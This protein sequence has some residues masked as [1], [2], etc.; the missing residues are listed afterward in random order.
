M[1]S[2]ESLAMGGISKGFRTARAGNRQRPGDIAKFQAV[3]D[4]SPADKLM[5][6]SCVE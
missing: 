1:F 2:Q 3:F 5:D 6:E 4:C